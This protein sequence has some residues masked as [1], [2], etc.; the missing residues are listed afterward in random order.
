MVHED[1]V[2]LV[3][4]DFIVD[5]AYT[6]FASI[7]LDETRD[8]GFSELDVEGT[9]ACSERSLTTVTLSELIKVNKEL[10][11]SYAVSSD[12]S[13]KFLFNTDL[14]LQFA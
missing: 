13:S 2:Q 11:D 6:S 7:L 5:K 14:S 1:F 3:T 9:N 12:Q 10:S 4:K 8:L